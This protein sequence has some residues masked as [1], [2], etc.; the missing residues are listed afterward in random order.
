MLKLSLA[1]FIV[2]KQINHDLFKAISRFSLLEDGSLYI[3]IFSRITNQWEFITM[4]IR[5]FET[6]FEINLSENN[7][8]VN[9]YK[10]CIKEYTL[11]ANVTILKD[12]IVVTEESFE[13]KITH[14][15]NDEEVLDYAESL[16]ETNEIYSFSIKEIEQLPIHEEKDMFFEQ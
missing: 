7:K 4:N 13:R 15:K 10:T 5:Q 16:L 2:N 9:L 6:E 12:K 8:F 14:C 11:L 1:T 3:Q